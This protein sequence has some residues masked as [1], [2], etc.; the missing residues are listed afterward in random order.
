MS[1]DL[2]TKLFEHYPLDDDNNDL[3]TYLSDKKVESA[4]DFFQVYADYLAQNVTNMSVS[5]CSSWA[6]CQEK[7]GNLST[8]DLD[9]TRRRTGE[10]SFSSESGKTT[11]FRE[12]AEWL[13][14]SY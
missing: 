6:I 11:T 10:W 9:Y 2:L 14:N 3:L 8:D 5:M 1:S 7:L 13:E 4:K 12:V